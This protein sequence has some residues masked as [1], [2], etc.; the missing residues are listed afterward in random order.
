MQIIK[1]KLKDIIKEAE[2]EVGEVSLS[3]TLKH[4]EFMSG[5]FF[6]IT[7][8]LDCGWT[9]VF[10]LN[11]YELTQHFVLGFGRLSKSKR[12]LLPSESDFIISLMPKAKH[13]KEQILRQLILSAKFS[14]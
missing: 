5:L 13:D 3:V 14:I 11:S 2:K 8:K 9:D 4:E 7:N 12:T 1:E 10:K 6:T